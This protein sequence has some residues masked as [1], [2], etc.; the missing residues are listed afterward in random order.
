MW[1]INRPELKAAFAEESVYVGE[2]QLETLCS[3]KSKEELLGDL[4]A[5]LQS[6]LRNVMSSLDS[7]KIILAGVVKTLSEREN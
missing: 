6:P 2:G 3:I 1:Q 4:V 5:L 7:G